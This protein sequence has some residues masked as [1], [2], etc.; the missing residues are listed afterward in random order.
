MKL[1]GAE[2]LAGATVALAEA[3]AIADGPPLRLP[4]LWLP[5]LRQRS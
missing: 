4:S 3:A 2:D 1:S 5:C